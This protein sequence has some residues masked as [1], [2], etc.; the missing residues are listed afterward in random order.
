MQSNKPIF[1]STVRSLTL[2]LLPISITVRTLVCSLSTSSSS[3][4]HETRSNESIFIV[5][6]PFTRLNPQSCSSKNYND[7]SDRYSNRISYL[8][9]YWCFFSSYFS[10]SS[11]YL[12][13]GLDKR[14]N[15]IMIIKKKESKLT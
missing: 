7:N 12:T 9:N 3:N 13:I 6:F 4:K 8:V 5:I 1:N 11:P 15:P 10:S 2:M 14:C